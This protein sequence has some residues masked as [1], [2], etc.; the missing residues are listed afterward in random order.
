MNG[1]W[2]GRPGVSP[3][4]V[5]TDGY[6]PVWTPDGQALYFS[7]YADV[8]GGAGVWRLDLSTGNSTHVTRA[9]RVDDFDVAGDLLVYTIAS[10]RARVFTAA[11]P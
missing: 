1:L 4:R 2:I 7:R 3:R 5:A 8:D 10:G 9:Q 11:L 6:G